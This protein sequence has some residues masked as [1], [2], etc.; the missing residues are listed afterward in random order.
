[1]QL[2]TVPFFTLSVEHCLR[3]VM[4][5]PVL[6][7]IYHHSASTP[8][9]IQTIEVVRP[10][11]SIELE[12]VS[13]ARD[14]WERDRHSARFGVFAIFCEVEPLGPETGL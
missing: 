6:L 7:V 14:S 11:R 4:V 3:I 8:I 1:M 13:G 9:V 10:N 2:D 5:R 12:L